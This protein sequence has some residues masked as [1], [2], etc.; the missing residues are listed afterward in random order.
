MEGRP[1]NAD[2]QG[3]LSHQNKARN[4]ILQNRPVFYDQTNNEEVEEEKEVPSLRG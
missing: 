2:Y 4:Q 1:E 3:M